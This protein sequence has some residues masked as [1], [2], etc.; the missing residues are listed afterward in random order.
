MAA[1]A[2]RPVGLADTAKHCP[3]HAQAPHG[4]PLAGHDCCRAAGCQCSC[5][6]TTASVNPP[7]T[8]TYL[9]LPCL[10]PAPDTPP[11]ESLSAELFKP[12]I[13]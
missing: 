9:T 4:S 6:L 1:A 3:G 11:A 7:G 8:G 12:P 2:A 10:I 5:S 13:A